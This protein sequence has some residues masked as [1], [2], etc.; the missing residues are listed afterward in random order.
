MPEYR[1]NKQKK[2]KEKPKK[3]HPKSKERKFSIKPAVD[4]NIQKSY[5]PVCHRIKDCYFYHKLKE[6]SVEEKLSFT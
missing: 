6:N 2:R 4:K 1:E 5:I 3:F